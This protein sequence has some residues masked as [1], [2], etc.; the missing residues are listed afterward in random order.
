MAITEKKLLKLKVDF[1]SGK[2]TKTAICKKHSVSHPTL[3]K[4]ADGN[5]WKFQKNFQ[6]IS[7]SVEQKTIERLIEKEADKLQ[8]INQ[9]YEAIIANIEAIA[10]AYIFEIGS[11]KQKKENQTKEEAERIFLFLKPLKISSEIFNMNYDRK[12]KILGMDAPKEGSPIN[13]YAQNQTVITDE[14]SARMFAEAM[15]KDG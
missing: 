11:N 6:K 10:K 3:R 9:E 2:L 4:H 12:R 15:E 7:E 8:R 13:V 14:E 5:E 1:E